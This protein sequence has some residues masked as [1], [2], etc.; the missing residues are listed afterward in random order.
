MCSTQKLAGQY[1]N[2]SKKMLMKQLSKI[3][4]S[5]ERG[6]YILAK[7]YILWDPWNDISML[8]KIQEKEINGRDFNSLID[9]FWRTQANRGHAFYQTN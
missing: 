6:F 7:Q 1:E 9:H 3:C 8:A 2:C 4:H 5:R